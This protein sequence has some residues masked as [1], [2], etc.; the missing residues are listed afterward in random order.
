MS[1]STFHT[2]AV[3]IAVFAAGFAPG[4]PAIAQ[5]TFGKS[6]ANVTRTQAQPT[7]TQSAAAAAQTKCVEL[8]KGQ[9]PLDSAITGLNAR[10]K[11]LEAKARALPQSAS[12]GAGSDKC[13]L[14]QQ[15]VATYRDNDAR[16]LSY[17]DHI[18]LA[19][20]FCPAQM[21]EKLVAAQIAL[22]KSQDV[23]ERMTIAHEGVLSASCR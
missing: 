21:T 15:I 17:L 18:A 2:H 11:E 20:K 22:K 3:L 5:S 4:K 7:E 10:A 14:Q 12:L 19:I 16:H 1:F 9:P 13:N 6:Q 8:L 23:V